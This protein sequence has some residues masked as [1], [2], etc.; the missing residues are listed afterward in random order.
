M[1]WFGVCV[2]NL[3]DHIIHHLQNAGEE[4]VCGVT[5]TAGGDYIR[6]NERLVETMQESY[7]CGQTNPSR[8]KGC[9]IYFYTHGI[10][11][12][13]Q[14]KYIYFFPVQIVIAVLVCNTQHQNNSNQT[15]LYTKRIIITHSP[16]YH[17]SN[18]PLYDSTEKIVHS[19]L[20]SPQLYPVYK[21]DIIVDV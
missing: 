21:S 15:P 11:N 18:H 5:I 9:K 12:A 3:K 7:E 17:L 2:S 20:Q 13:F 16:Q 8:C 14:F 4:A 19:T 6:N 1:Y 10:R